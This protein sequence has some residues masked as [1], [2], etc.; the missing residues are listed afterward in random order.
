MRFTQDEKHEIILLV[1][2]SDLSA[3]WKSQ[4]P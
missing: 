1:D 4:C 3:N 2:G